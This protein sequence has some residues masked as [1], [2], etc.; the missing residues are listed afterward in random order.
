MV[1][2]REVK[3]VKRGCEDSRGIKQCGLAMLMLLHDNSNQNRLT[4][5]TSDEDVEER[6]S[7]FYLP[8]RFIWMHVWTTMV[9]L[10]R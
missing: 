4:V 5:V 10:I 7:I 2:K 8:C 3:W 9:L 6:L 1:L